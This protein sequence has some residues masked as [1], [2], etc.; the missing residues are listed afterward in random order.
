MNPKQSTPPFE[1]FDSHNQW[2]CSFIFSTLILQNHNHFTQS[3][4]NSQQPCH[5]MFNVLV[6]WW[7][8]LVPLA[9]DVTMTTTLPARFTISCGLHFNPRFFPPDSNFLSPQGHVYRYQSTSTNKQL[10]CEFPC[11]IKGGSNSQSPKQGHN[12]LIYNSRKEQRE[13]YTYQFVSSNLY[14]MQLNSID[15]RLQHRQYSMFKCKIIAA[16]L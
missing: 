10:S 9:G 16:L 6:W 8:A 4:A 1:Y 14:W 2:T 3:I 7:I 13:N 12:V 15:E 5:E 11:E